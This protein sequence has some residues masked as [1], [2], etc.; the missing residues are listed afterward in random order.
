MNMRLTGTGRALPSIIPKAIAMTIRASNG[1]CIF[2]FFI[3]LKC[4]SY[5]FDIGKDTKIIEN[6]M[7]LNIILASS[8]IKNNLCKFAGQLKPD[9]EL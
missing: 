3:R 7:I 5:L 8:A 6:R 4:G 2:L 1:T 9:Y